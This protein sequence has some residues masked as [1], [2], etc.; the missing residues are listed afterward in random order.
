MIVLHAQNTLKFEWRTAS[1]NIGK[2]FTLTKMTDIHSTHRVSHI[3]PQFLV[4]TLI[5]SLT[6]WLISIYTYSPNTACETLSF[7]GPNENISSIVY[8]SFASLQNALALALPPF[9]LLCTKLKAKNDKMAEW[10]RFQEFHAHVQTHW[11]EWAP[12][13]KKKWTKAK[14]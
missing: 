10:L 1:T 4:K 8:H 3:F 13:K 11:L 9:C 5:H 7:W 12:S 6:H 2:C 14:R